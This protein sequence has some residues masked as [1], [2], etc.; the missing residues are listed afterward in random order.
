MIDPSAL[1]SIGGAVALIAGLVGSAIGI[2]TAASGGLAT[3]S[4][5]PRQFRN[6]LILASLP[7]TQS[8]YGLIVLILIITGVL[9]NMP[10]E[11]SAGLV[12]LAVSLIA[13][14]AFGFSAVYQGMVCASGIAM[15]PKTGGKI[16][17]SSMMLAVF[18]ELIA[19]LALVFTIMAFTLLGLM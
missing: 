9:P 3:L 7:M 16:L 1:A 2:A 19:V 17:T 15:L 12:A 18:V 13:A 5:D 11:G 10:A 8:F 4:E 14:F 6:V